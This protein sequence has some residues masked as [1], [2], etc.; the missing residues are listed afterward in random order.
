MTEMP[1][2]PD[3]DEMLRELSEV[4]AE[5]L[6]VGA[7]AVGAH[8]RARATKDLDI[9][10]RPSPENARRVWHALLKFGAP[11]EELTIEDLAIPGTIF[12]MGRPPHRIDIITSIR[13]VEFET[14]WQ[15][16]VVAPYGTG[17]YFVLGRNE[18]ILNKKAVGRPQDLIDL[19]LLRKYPSRL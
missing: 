12:Q 11:L 7:Y 16:R 14:A 19:D 3:F 10:V 9:W 1:F 6:I 2:G 13:G 17:T 4:G 18:L 15:N 5:Y 8:V